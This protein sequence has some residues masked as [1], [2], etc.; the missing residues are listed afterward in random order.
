MIRKNFIFLFFHDKDVEKAFFFR[1]ISNSIFPRRDKRTRRKVETICKKGRGT[2]H[3]EG[4]K[5]GRCRLL[6][7]GVRFMGC[8]D[9]GSGGG[10]YLGVSPRLDVI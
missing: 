1:M 2:N 3:G 5:E 9:S 7:A 6:R 4:K 8:N 10:M